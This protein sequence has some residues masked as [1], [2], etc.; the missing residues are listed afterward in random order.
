ML[1]PLGII[2]S[3]VISE[4]EISGGVESMTT[5]LCDDVSTFPDVS[6]TIQ[7]TIVSPSG[8]FSGASLDSDSILT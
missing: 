5:T 4:T 7:V 8:K 6:E 1:L 2:A 3:T